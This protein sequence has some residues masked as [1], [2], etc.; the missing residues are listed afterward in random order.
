MRNMNLKATFQIRVS[1]EEKRAIQD[2]ARR[3]NFS[4]TSTFIRKVLL[5]QVKKKR[6]D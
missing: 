1:E 5:D 4:T 2:E 6:S 3:Q